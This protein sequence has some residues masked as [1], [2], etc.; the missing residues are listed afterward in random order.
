MS[1]FGLHKDESFEAWLTEHCN[2][3]CKNCGLYQPHKKETCRGVERAIEEGE[4]K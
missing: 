3:D 4:N 1:Y 2:S